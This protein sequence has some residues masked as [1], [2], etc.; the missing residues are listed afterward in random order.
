ML[1]AI[2]CAGPA[3]CSPLRLSSCCYTQSM[4]W[5]K[6]LASVL[7]SARGS[8]RSHALTRRVMRWRKRAPENTSLC[9][10]VPLQRK[11][12]HASR[13]AVQR[14][15]SSLEDSRC[16]LHVCCL[17]SLLVKSAHVSSS[18][19]K[20]GVPILVRAAGG[21]PVG[22]LTSQSTGPMQVAAQ[23]ICTEACRQLPSAAST[24]APSMS[25]SH[26]PADNQKFTGL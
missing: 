21:H 5:H 10:L 3:S 12:G 4:A 22:C 15:C 18:G 11:C 25:E 19:S 20:V 24:P 7:A 16:R 8:V 6:R 17:S 9:A 2:S 13:I 26:S 14:A 23:G 1:P